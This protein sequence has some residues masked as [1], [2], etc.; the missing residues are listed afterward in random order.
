MKAMIGADE[1]TSENTFDL[2]RAIDSAPGF[3]MDRVRA[4]LAGEFDAALLSPDEA[5]Y[6]D[7]MLGEAMG[8]IMTP[9]G[10]RF[11]ATFDGLTN[12]DLCVEISIS[13]PAVRSG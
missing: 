12:T 9:A 4:A 3:T 13:S 10:R 6:F 11:W 1:H 5:V 2:G 8:N 7:E